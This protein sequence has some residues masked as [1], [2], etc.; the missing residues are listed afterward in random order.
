MI[1]HFFRALFYA[2]YNGDAGDVVFLAEMS[3]AIGDF[4]KS[5]L[6][7]HLPFPGDDKIR[8][9]QQVFKIQDFQD[10]LNSGL[11]MRMG[12]SKKSC[13][14]TSS[15]AGSGDRPDIFLAEFLQ[16]LAVMAHALFQYGKLTGRAAFLGAKNS[17]GTL[18]T[19]KRILYIAHDRKRSAL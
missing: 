6:L 9:R 15:R 1:F 11:Q 10:R 18:G 8:V 17:G 19:G 16:K 3:Y 12:E 5:G 2:A 4:T 13:S 7:I 14:E